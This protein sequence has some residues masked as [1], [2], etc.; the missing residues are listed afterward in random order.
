VTLGTTLSLLQHHDGNFQAFNTAFAYVGLLQHGVPTHACMRSCV[1]LYSC[2][3]HSPE[4]SGPV[5]CASMGLLPCMAGR[6]TLHT[7][8]YVQVQCSP[9]R[10]LHS[11]PLLGAVL[12]QLWV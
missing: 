12:W 6:V 4:S 8:G 11:L 1:C 2:I 9:C 3:L 7:S 5:C 10:G